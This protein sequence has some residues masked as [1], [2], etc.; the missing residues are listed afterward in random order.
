MRSTSSK[1]AR[2]P[3]S[4]IRRSMLTMCA[5]RIFRAVDDVRHLHARTQFIGLRLHRENADVARLDVGEDFAGHVLQRPW[6]QVFQ[7]EGV[8]VHA[9][10]L[11][12]RRQRRADLQARAIRDQGH[13][14][15]G[16]YAETDSRW[17]C[18]LPVG[19]PGR[20]TSPAARSSLGSLPLSRR[21]QARREESK[22]GFF[23]H[24]IHHL[25]EIARLVKDL[26]LPVGTGAARPES[27]GCSRSL[28]GFP[29]RPLRHRQIPGY[30][31][32]NSAPGTS[33]FLPKSI[34]FPSSP[35]RL[36]AICS[37]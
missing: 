30:S 7:N 12:F 34:N 26:Q 13:F 22:L 21:G 28:R 37:P 17:R 16:L 29:V 19:S 1:S 11:E 33:V 15:V 27:Y 36:P 10:A 23:D 3:S 5:W 20:T 2:M 35:Y 14:L 6:R 8:I 31:T 4:M 24:V 25:F 9:E 18:A 32:I